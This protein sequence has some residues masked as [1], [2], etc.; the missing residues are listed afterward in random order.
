[1]PH[2]TH[3]SPIRVAILVFSFVLAVIA[4]G[5]GSI[6][7]I[8]IKESEEVAEMRPPLF[9]DRTT[10]TQERERDFTDLYERVRPSILLMARTHATRSDTQGIE[11]V[12]VQGDIVSPAL[13]MTTDGWVVL[14]Q[15]PAGMKLRGFDYRGNSLRVGTVIKESSLGIAF[16]KMSG[17]DLHAAAF[18]AM[19]SSRPSLGFLVTEMRV[20]HLPLSAKM[21]PAPLTSRDVI[22]SS[23]VLEKRLNPD[24]VSREPGF[25]VVDAQG[26]IIG[27]TTERGI[28]P[29][30][31]IKD[32]LARIVRSGSARG[33]SLGVHYIDLAHTVGAQDPSSGSRGSPTG[34]R[35]VSSSKTILV[36]TPKG[37]ARLKDGDRILSV[38]DESID[39]NRSLSELIAQYKPKDTVTLKVEYGGSVRDITVQLQ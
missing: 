20:S 34:A 30:S 36:P 27:I 4:G 33:P 18:S 5:L 21:Y 35:L 11:R 8:G 16:A 26:A 12:V 29:V 9:D 14:P 39:S 19:D 15:F 31:A 25:P 13:A 24:D 10:R 22:R 2:S 1:M 17:S 37:T 28:I 23:D 38:N 3:H 32:A 7:M 6:F